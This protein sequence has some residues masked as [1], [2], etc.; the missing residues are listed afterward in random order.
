[1]L[2]CVL[3]YSAV[4]HWQASGDLRQHYAETALGS[5]GQTVIAVVQTLAA[6]GLL[7]P[8]FQLATAFIVTI[9]M[10]IASAMHI[11]SEG[12]KATIWQP[13]C[14][15]AW[16]LVPAIILRVTQK[17]QEHEPGSEKA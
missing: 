13:A 2:G 3:A 6:I 9:V 4:E 15:G 11:G 5:G 14:I 17:P 1:M 12:I 8:R 10:L 16:A 7:W